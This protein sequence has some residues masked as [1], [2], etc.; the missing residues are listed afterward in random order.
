MELSVKKIAE[1]IGAEIKGDDSISVSGISDLEN[2][3]ESD[4][5]FILSEKN[6]EAARASKAPAIISSLG[7]EITGKTLLKVNNSRSAYAQVISI[8]NPLKKPVKSVSKTAVLAQS[9]K[10]G[11]GAAVGEFC[12]AGENTVIGDGACISANCVIGENC[13]IGGGT[14]IYPGVVIYDNTKIGKNTVIHSGCVIGADGFGFVEDNGKIV[15]VPQIGHVEIGSNAEIGANCTIDRAAFGATVIEDNVKLDNL[16]HVAHNCVV[17]EGTI[18]AAQTGISGSVK[19]GKYC[20]IGGQ[21]GFVD[22]IEIG[23]MVRIGSQAGVTKDLPDKSAV[24]GAPARPIMEM[25]KSDAYVGKLEGLFKRV[26]Q[27]ESEVKQMKDK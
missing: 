25:R 8:F 27:L 26:K 20:L 21:V 9:V 13:D 18:I 1:A 11:K 19:L 14:V 24:T 23:N 17:G 10:L 16:I 15:K 7:Q 12:V 5:S 6:I 4:I 2:A 3:S 22:H